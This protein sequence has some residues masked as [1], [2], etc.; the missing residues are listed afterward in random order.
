M[1]A[2]ELAKHRQHYMDELKRYCKEKVRN[3]PEPDEDE[4]EYF[5]SLIPD[6]EIIYNVENGRDPMDTIVPLVYYNIVCF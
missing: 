2:T 6:S 1:E 4:F 5:M 3:G